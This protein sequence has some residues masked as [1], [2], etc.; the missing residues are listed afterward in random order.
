MS[1]PFFPL[2]V[3]DFEADTAHLTLE[4][5]GAYNRLLRLCWRTPGCSLPD[6][7]DWIYRKARARTD[8]DKAAVDIVIDEFF[9]VEDGRVFNARLRA[10]ALLAGER[11]A[12]RVAA[13][14]KGGQ[15]SNPLKTNETGSSIAKAKPKQPQPQP[16]TQLSDDNCEGQAPAKKTRTHATRLP[17]DWVLPRDWGEWALS[18]G[19]AEQ[20][21]RAEA[22]RFRDH[23]IAAGGQNARKRDW[24]ATWRNWMRRTPKLKTIN[25]AGYEKPAAKS[26]SRVNAFIA[27]ARGS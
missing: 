2:Y 20:H 6:D 14:R 22:E 7:R 12:R 17:E 27:G 23:W 24:K 13:G 25:G 19:W 5:D 11:H 18:E 3:D 15:K 1:L 16:Q 4:E 9:E 26:E 10:E 21:I 8:A